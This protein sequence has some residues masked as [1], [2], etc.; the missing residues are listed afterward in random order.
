MP[1]LLALYFLQ[2][3]QKAHA[4]VEPIIAPLLSVE[5]TEFRQRKLTVDQAVVLTQNIECNFEEKKAS[6]VFVDLTA[7]FDTVWRLSLT[8]KLHRLL[9]NKHMIRMIMELL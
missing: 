1:D 8:C 9:P 3:P 5:Q 6:A 4:C 2:D 7:A